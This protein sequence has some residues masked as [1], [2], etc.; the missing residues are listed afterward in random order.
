MNPEVLMY[1][2]RFSYF[3]LPVNRERAIELVRQEV[4]AARQSGMEA[5]LLIPLTRGHGDAALQFEIELNSLD[6]FESFRH[7]GVGSE[8]GTRDWISE[9][10]NLLLSPPAVEILRIDMD[11]HPS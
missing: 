3:L 9:F 7:Q 5:R 10:S 2:A 11:G 8:A 6:Q 4:D 1:I